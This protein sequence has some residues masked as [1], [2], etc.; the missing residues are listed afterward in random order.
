MKSFTTFLKEEAEGE[1]LKH[2]THA[3]DRPLQNGAEGFKLA[4]DTLHQAHGH[5]KGGANSSACS[6]PYFKQTKLPLL[7]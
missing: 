5:I 6:E 3:E 2:I 4:H 7:S 1:K